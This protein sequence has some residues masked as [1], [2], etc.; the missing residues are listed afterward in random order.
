MR[1]LGQ[2]FLFDEDILERMVEYGEVG[3]GD[4]VL[5]VG[6]GIGVL[7]E[8]LARRAGK[9]IAVEI[10]EEL[11]GE[12]RR[13]L[14]GR[15]NVELIV[16]DI[17]EMDLRS[18]NKV[19]ANPPYGISLRLM[20]WLIERAP[21]LMVLTLQREFIGKLKAS[22]GT[23]KYTFI[24]FLTQLAYQ[25]EVKEVIPRKLF[26]P[27]PRVDSAITLFTRRRG[28]DYVSQEEWRIA[29]MLFTRRRQRISKVVK[30]MMGEDASKA[31]EKLPYSSKRVYQLRPEEL[32]SCVRLIKAGV[33]K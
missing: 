2:H 13:R 4:T 17:L 16:G 18:F 25:V 22:P 6:A 27:P 7:T 33:N 30:D 31:V 15:D 29:R 19:V 23:R 5:E 28:L 11:A 14:M 3:L 32:L 1:R 8:K 24:S 9:V 10:D 20:E 21:E 26:T 12:A